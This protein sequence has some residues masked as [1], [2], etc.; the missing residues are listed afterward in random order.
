ME[1]NEAPKEKKY[2]YWFLAGYY[3][4]KVVAWL[5]ILSVPTTIYREFLYGSETKGIGGAI[6]VL[7]GVYLLVNTKKE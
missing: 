4:R 2:S 1:T 5:F 6:L 7:A 3:F